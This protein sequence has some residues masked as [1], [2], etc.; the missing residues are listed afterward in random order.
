[1]CIVVVVGGHGRVATSHQ[2]AP[3]SRGSDLR[4]R[5]AVGA[6]F[7]S[8]SV[9]GFARSQSDMGI[10]QRRKSNPGTPQ[11]L[12]SAHICSDGHG[13]GPVELWTCKTLARRALRKVNDSISA[14]THVVVE[15]QGPLA[16]GTLFAW[17]TRARSSM[18][19][20]LQLGTF[21]GQGVQL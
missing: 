2:I 1:M 6:A 21:L 13:H 18:D 10:A 7:R 20:A 15:W 5:T 16:L 8:T 17:W 3:G 14:D 4:S 9:G 19:D 12:G 11:N